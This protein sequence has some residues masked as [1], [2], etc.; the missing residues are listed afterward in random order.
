MN[1]L[2]NGPD[3]FA[4]FFLQENT[5]LTYKINWKKMYDLRQQCL[6]VCFISVHICIK[7]F[8]LD[9]I[10]SKLCACEAHNAHSYT[11]NKFCFNPL[12]K[13]DLHYI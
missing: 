7:G 4:A 6:K 12:N 1:T 11:D 13:I 2:L 9:Q 5:K 10:F 3:V 8:L